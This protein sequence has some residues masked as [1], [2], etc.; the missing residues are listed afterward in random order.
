MAI[1]ATTSR[2][3]GTAARPLDAAQWLRT[4][5]VTVSAFILIGIQLWLKGAMLAGGYFRQDDFLYLDR[6]LASGFGW[7]YLIWQDAGHLLPLGMAISWLEARIELYDWPVAIGVVLLLLTAASCAMLRMLRTLF[8]NKPAILIPLGIFLFSPLSLAG[9][10]WWAVAIEILPLEIAMFMAIDAHVRYLRSGQLRRAVAAAGWLAAGM[11][12]RDSG[13]IVPLLLLALTAAFFV[14]RPLEVRRYWRAWALY[15]AVLAV[16]AAIFFGSLSGS[17]AKP[18]SPGSLGHVFSFSATLLSSSLVPG[19]LGGPW[20]WVGGV[21]YAQA[22]PPAGLQQLSWAVAL[23]V[24]LVTCAWR[25][26]AWRAWAIL[27][28]WVVVA[29]ILPV[30]ISRLSAYPGNLLG[31]LTRYVTDATGVLALCVGLAVLP[32]AGEQHVYRFQLGTM[33]RPLAALTA[34]L[35]CAVAA[36]SI[37]S[38]T[39]L[40]SV[41]NATASAAQSYVATAQAALADTPPGTMIVSSAVP[42]I[43]MDPGLFWDHA[44][45]SQVIAP[46]AAHSQHLTWTTMLRGVYA[47]PM[48][49]DGRGQLRPVNVVGE[50]SWP[51]PRVRSGQY[52]GQDCWSV[53][54]AGTSVALL[55]P[56]YPYAWTVRVA[57][58]GP[59]TQLAVGLGGKWSTVNLEA[60]THTAYVPVVGGGKNVTLAVI[61]AAS[62]VCVSGVTVGST[63]PD[64]TVQGIPAVPLSG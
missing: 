36:G 62:D 33:R 8:G 19:A 30:I 44:L 63:Q 21:G 27:A 4:R 32:L 45:T 58:T 11:A 50:F 59:A 60:G 46:L 26:R 12:A 14:A 5:G 40:Q 24:V 53:T 22:G 31:E 51:A 34:A 16:Y 47:N 17:T 43:I 41:S 3:D 42:E 15:G 48:I 13:A 1:P 18:G 9:S 35:L 64:P 37:W 7:S 25:V 10:D 49:F 54:T 56:I 6:S 2:S 20:H 57:Y 38:L 39:S 23:I 55:G 28:G 29:D 61:G 52:A